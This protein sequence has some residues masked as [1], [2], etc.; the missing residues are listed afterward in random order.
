MEN[1]YFMNPV[2]DIAI[3]ITSVG[4]GKTRINGNGNGNRK[5]NGNRNGNGGK[6]YRSYPDIQGI[7]CDKAIHFRMASGM[8]VCTYY[9][10]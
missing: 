5:G 10:W 7:F 1:S 6:I 4:G 2:L 3:P 8:Y 9:E